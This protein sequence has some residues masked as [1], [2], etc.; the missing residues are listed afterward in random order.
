V[1]FIVPRTLALHLLTPLCLP[2]SLSLSFAIAFFFSLY[3]LYAFSLTFAKTIDLFVQGFWVFF[4]GQDTLLFLRCIREG[5][6][7]LAFLVVAD[8]S[9]SRRFN[10]MACR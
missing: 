8:A 6:F 2:A 3:F 7:V 9:P 10:W 5:I 1:I 4:L